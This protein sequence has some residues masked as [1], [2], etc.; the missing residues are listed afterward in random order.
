MAR[1]V[2][3]RRKGVTP[4]TLSS[5]SGIAVSRHAEPLRVLLHDFGHPVRQPPDGEL[6]LKVPEIHMRHMPVLPLKHM[7]SCPFAFQV[8][9]N[10]DFKSSSCPVPP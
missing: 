10:C 4:L 3:M 7:A 6:G 2:E 8:P 5:I 9:D 1:R